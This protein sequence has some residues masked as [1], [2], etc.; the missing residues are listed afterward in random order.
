[1]LS[2]LLLPNPAI[3]ESTTG[4]NKIGEYSYATEFHIPSND[5]SLRKE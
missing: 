1:M 5:I 3:E 2:A 4:K